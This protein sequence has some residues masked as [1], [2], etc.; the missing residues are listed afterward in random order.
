MDPTNITAKDCP[1]TTSNDY[2]TLPTMNEY[3]TPHSQS[4][5]YFELSANFTVEDDVGYSTVEPL[6]GNEPVYEDPGHN[7]E[8]I[9]AWF[10]KKKFRVLQRNDIQ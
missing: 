7:K 6:P 10:E 3:E 1:K 9:Y 4:Q 2:M 8:K 5:Y